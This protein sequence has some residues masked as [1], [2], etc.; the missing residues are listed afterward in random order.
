MASRLDEKV[1]RPLTHTSKIT[2]AAIGGLVAVILWFLVAWGIQLTQG[3]GVTGMRDLGVPQLGAPWGVYISN[4]VWFVGVAHGGIAVSAAVRV[5]KI[6]KYRPITRMAEVLTLAA[7]AMAGLSIIFDIGRPD[8]LWHI[9]V[10]YFERVGLSP[11]VWDITVIFA[12]FILSATFM[13]LLMREDLATYI[14]RASGREKGLFKRLLIGYVYKLLLIGYDKNERAKIDQITWWMALTILALIALLS[15][16]VVPW[17]FGL[18]PSQ[19]LWFGAFQGPYFLAAALASA[20]AAVIVVAAIFR[21]LFKWQQYI[22]L[23]IFRGLGTMLGVLTATYMWFMLQ[24]HIA[25]RY[26]GPE[27]ELR[28]ADA[29]FTGGLA[30]FFWPVVLALLLPFLYLFAQTV[31]P[32]AFSVKGIVISSLVIL[33]AFWVKRFLIIVPSLLF[34][35]MPYPSGLYVPTYIEWS[36]VVGTFAITALVFIVFAKMFPIMELRRE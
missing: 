29:L 27:A 32:R 11:L 25:I 14:E 15:G 23:D 5:M 33:V 6:E 17:L 12:Y 22:K 18:M 9:L 28:V 1:T 20:I 3:L 26:A 35:R 8:R 36:L 24:E 4:F 13:V 31:Y 7:L 10:Y 19:A 16:G 34:P 30:V 21:S 2:Y